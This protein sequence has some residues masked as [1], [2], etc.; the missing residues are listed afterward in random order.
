MTQVRV[1][2]LAFTGLL[3]CWV[4]SQTEIAFAFTTWWLCIFWNQNYFC[5]L[6]FLH[7]FYSHYSIPHASW[8][9]KYANYPRNFQLH[10]CDSHPCHLPGQSHAA[11]TVV[12]TVFLTAVP[13]RCSPWEIWALHGEHRMGWM[14]LWLSVDFIVHIDIVSMYGIF[15]YLPLVNF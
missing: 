15:I 1:C 10:S 7:F 6:S 14:M 2:G 12:V 5:A 4:E 13:W 11:T 8:L 9:E 3:H